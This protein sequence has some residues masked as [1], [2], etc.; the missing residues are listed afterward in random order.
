MA[1]GVSVH[2][3]CQRI[4]ALTWLFP[5]NTCSTAIAI[6]E[7]AAVIIAKEL[8]LTLQDN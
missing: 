3:V 5:Q 6:G 4:S 8:G 2:A 1:S 7:K